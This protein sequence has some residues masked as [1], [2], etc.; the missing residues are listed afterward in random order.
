MK[1]IP[2]ID[3]PSWASGFRLTTSVCDGCGRSVT[4]RHHAAYNLGIRMHEAWYCGARCFTAAVERVL[5]RLLASTPDATP[6]VERMPLGLLLVSRGCLSMEQLR[7]ITQQQRDAGEDVGDLLSAHGM[8]SEKQVAA[9]RAMQ[10][11]C[12][13]FAVPAQGVSAAICLPPALVKVYS[14]TSLHYGAATNQLLVGFVRYIDYG[15]LYAIEHIAGCKTQ[16]CFITPSDFETQ[17]KAQS[18]SQFAGP[19]MFEAP[20]PAE[21]IAQIVCKHALKAEAHE[22]F[23][24]KC[25]EY[26][27]VRLK[28]SGPAQD[29]LFRTSGLT[30]DSTKGHT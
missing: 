24:A 1:L 22:A 27:W 21:E 25:K 15:L 30:R 23:I 4:T 13:L 26:M 2:F 16:A 8:V 18:Q 10:W 9:A 6:R 7:S 19:A 28:T 11:N 29:L 12:P 5:L 17:L 3:V 14:A 20:R